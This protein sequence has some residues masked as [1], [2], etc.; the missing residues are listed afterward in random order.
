MHCD[1]AFWVG[2]THENAR[3][4]AEL[5][6]LPGAAGIKVFMGSSTGSLLVEDD[7]GVDRD[8]APDAPPRRLP[9]RGR[10]PPAR[11][12]ATCASPATRRPI[13]VW[14]DAEA[15]LTLHP[16][17]RRGSRARPARASTCCTSRPPRRCAFLAD[18]K[19]VATV[20]VTPH[21][22]TLVGAGCYERLGTLRR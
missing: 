22:L 3:D 11:A 7:E 14:R 12:R 2:G 16:A 6:R 1:F 13:P 15:A 20:E 5:E 8:P 4:V 9:L 19:D 10:V 18:H 17:P 21:H